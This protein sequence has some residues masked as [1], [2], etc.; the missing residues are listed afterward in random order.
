MKR[1]A[2]FIG[3]N[4]YAD[5]KIQNLRYAVGDAALLFA[6]FKAIGYDAELLPNPTRSAV[7]EK[8][9]AMTTGMDG[10][11]DVFLFYFA[12]HGFVAPGDDERLFCKDDFYEKLQYHGAG[13]SF[14][15]LRDTTGHGGLRRIFILDACRLNVFAGQRGIFKP[16]DLLPISKLMGNPVSSDGKGRFGGHAIW[17]SCSPR[18]CAMELEQFEHGLFSLAIDMVMTACRNT[19]Q[20]LAF[21]R[22]FMHLVVEKMRE[23]A[24]DGNQTPEEQYSGNWPNL[25]LINGRK[26]HVAPPLPVA[27]SFAAVQE[28]EEW[29]KDEKRRRIVRCLLMFLGLW[30]IVCSVA[31]FRVLL[32]PYTDATE[33]NEA[34]RNGTYPEAWSGCT[35]TLPGGAEL[36]LVYCPPGEFMMGSPSTEE[37]RWRDETQHRVWLTKGFWLGKYPVTQRQWRSV[38]G[39]NPSS[40]VGDDLPVD[41]VSWYDCQ[42]F[43]KKVNVAL[44]CGARLPTEAEWEY[45]CRAGTTG[46]YGGTGNLDEMGWFNGNSGNTTHPVGQKKP[47]AWGL[48]D[49]H[50]NV[51]EWCADWWGGYPTD[52]VVDPAG[53]AS[54]YERV[55]RG[56]NWHVGAQG[57]RTALRSKGILSYR[58]DDCGFRLC[59][60]VGS[61]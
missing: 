36:E 5:Q 9:A 18:Q 20:T 37:G 47:N 25:V 6:Q 35:I 56:G 7:E 52:G 48:Y 15:M 28:E 60:S 11:D 61:L 24:P 3:V 30:L 45:A 42:E 10:E 4:E 44:E 41:G 26:A 21:S 39:N 19:G 34:L 8:V 13:I 38:M 22:P 29:G 27:N 55:L 2:L 1:K 32:L 23:I 59:C 40:F 12:G 14:A 43:I 54:G 49:M 17:R 16:R 51:W 58:H 31:V 57:C 53:T 33:R 50:G 46:V